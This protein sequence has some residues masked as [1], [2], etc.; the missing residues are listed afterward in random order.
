MR[1]LLMLPPCAYGYDSRRMLVSNPSLDLATSCSLHNCINRCICSN[2]CIVMPVRIVCNACCSMGVTKKTFRH[3]C[4]GPHTC[5]PTWYQ[6]HHVMI[7]T[8]ANGTLRFVAQSAI[9]L[10]RQHVQINT[11]ICLSMHTLVLI[12]GAI[13]TCTLA[14][15]MC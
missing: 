12:L 2:T 14:R 5:T 15:R 9:W 6:H 4:C 13:H 7:L 11:R 8:I 1:H 10:H 3:L